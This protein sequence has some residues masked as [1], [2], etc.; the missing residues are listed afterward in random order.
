MTF[1]LKVF[2][3]SQGQNLGRDSFTTRLSDFNKLAIKVM[4]MTFQKE[5]PKQIYY[6]DYKNLYTN[7]YFK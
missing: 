7:V 6:R 3:I 4:K 2:S 1:F 5:A